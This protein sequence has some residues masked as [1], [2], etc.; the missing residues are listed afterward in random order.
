MTDEI[1]L[2]YENFFRNLI[3]VSLENILFE[4]VKSKSSKYIP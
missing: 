1:L 4:I 3:K 2:F